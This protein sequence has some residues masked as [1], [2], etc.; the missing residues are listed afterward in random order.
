MDKTAE[1]EGCYFPSM[2]I[3]R[4]RKKPD[5]VAHI[6]NPNTQKTNKEE[7]RV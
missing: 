7:M 2:L 4:T 3:G 5:T 1:E 6:C